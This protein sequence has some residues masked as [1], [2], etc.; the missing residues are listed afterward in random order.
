MTRERLQLSA[1]A[2]IVVLWTD[3]RKLSQKLAHR[4]CPKLPEIGVFLTTVK[5]GT[6]S[7]LPGRPLCS[8]VNLQLAI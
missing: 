7:E 6:L 1:E 4:P 8:P 3:L 2:S 5:F